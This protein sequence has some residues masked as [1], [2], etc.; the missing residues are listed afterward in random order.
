MNHAPCY[1]FR[2]TRRFFDA[3]G[4]RRGDVALIGDS[5]MYSASTSGWG[6]GFPY[7]LGRRYRTYASGVHPAGALAGYSLDYKSGYTSF[8]SEVVPASHSAYIPGAG[9]AGG[10]YIYRATTGDF[11]QFVGSLDVDHPS[12]NSGNLRWHY[13]YG[14]FATGSGGKFQP[15]FR[16]ESS[17]SYPLVGSQVNTTTGTNALVRSYLELPAA[18]RNPSL[19]IL[20][21]YQVHA[22]SI[23]GGNIAASGPFLGI[24]QRWEWRDITAGVGVSTLWYTGGVGTR[25]AAAALQAMTQTQFNAWVAMVVGPQAV[26][27]G[28]TPILHVHIRNG[29][30][31]T[32]DVT[33]SVGPNPVASNTIAGAIDNHEACI[34]AIRALW[35][36]AGYDA[37]NLTFSFGYQPQ[38]Y[39][40]RIW[41][42]EID[43][44]L[45]ALADR[46][47]NT[48]V[49]FRSRRSTS[50]LFSAHSR[51]AEAYPGDAHLTAQGYLDAAREE[52][53]ACVPVPTAVGK[54]STAASSLAA[55]A[56]DGNQPWSVT[57]NS[58]GLWD[59]DLIEDYEI[60]VEQLGTSDHFVVEWPV[61]LARRAGMKMFVYVKAGAA[62]AVSDIATAEWEFDAVDFD[63]SRGVSLAAIADDGVV[64]DGVTVDVVD[65]IQDGL[66]TASAQTTAQASLTA[67]NAKTTNLPASPAASTDA[68]SAL[69]ANGLTSSWASEVDSQSLA[70]QTSSATALANT[71]TILSRIGAIAGSGANTIKGY[72]L[73]LLSKVA[74]TPSDIG[75]TFDP[76]S[77][78]VEAIRDKV[79]TLATSSDVQITISPA[80]AQA[81]QIDP[82]D[83]QLRVSQY[84]APTIKF[85]CFDRLGVAID[86]SGKT[87]VFVAATTDGITLTSVFTRTSAGGAITVTGADD[88]EANVSLA[89]ANTSTAREELQFFLWNT[90]DN[91]LLAKGGLQ[92]PPA[93]QA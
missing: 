89:Q 65:E 79:D 34:V 73:A 39:S 84:S 24:H 53:D 60:A 6:V 92:I 59:D 69:A 38:D 46:M 52:L 13:D 10:E 57:H 19:R 30:N 55:V 74:A 61:G 16:Y 49:W 8:A 82:N 29:Q 80:V 36:G 45:C 18:A 70:A 81:S 5:N 9:F 68:A 93:L 64:V 33:T 32:G 37:D 85:T 66:A 41:C 40:R 87:L 58:L 47:G 42:Y 26:D 75:G 23:G 44:A 15:C 25:V 35:T 43:D 56:F 21:Q 71:V 27:A 7:A 4:Y 11:G 3:L 2:A 78:S 31:D 1:N 90:T 22:A 12:D 54:S 91:I 51:Y 77:D 14:T 72:F 83:I 88:N 20:A 17:L 48:A 76:A 62:L 86:L 67:I 50:A 63:G 28:E